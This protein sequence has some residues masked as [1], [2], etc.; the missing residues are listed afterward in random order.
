M[1]FLALS[2]IW[3]TPGGLPC[4]FTVCLTFFYTVTSHVC[5]FL[6]LLP[7]NVEKLCLG[8]SLSLSLFW[9]WPNSWLCGWCLQ[10]TWDFWSFW[11]SFTASE[12]SL[13]SGEFFGFA[14]LCMSSKRFYRKLCTFLN[15]V[16]WFKI[17]SPQMNLSQMQETECGGV[18]LPHIDFISLKRCT[19]AHKLNCCFKELLKVASQNPVSE[20][21]RSDNENVIPLDSLS[22]NSP[23]DF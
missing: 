10:R 22:W 3:Q 16:Q 17:N 4:L 1:G 6:R 20:A 12:I 2:G 14:R 7:D 19:A 15:H 23:R 8:C 5:P 11:G 21:V 13:S 9:I 18:H